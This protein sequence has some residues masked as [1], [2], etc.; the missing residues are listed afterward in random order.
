MAV[1]VAVAVAQ[2]VDPAAEGLPPHPVPGPGPGHLLVSSRRHLTGGGK[3]LLQT[4]ELILNLNLKSIHTRST[5]E[6]ITSIIGIAIAIIGIAITTASTN[7]VL[8]IEI[9]D[10]SSPFEVVHAR[11]G[12]TL[13]T[14]LGHPSTCRS[15]GRGMTDIPLHDSCSIDK[16]C[17][18]GEEK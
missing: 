14:T 18:V 3:S 4:Q 13:A 11:A 7:S 9:E 8:E 10:V 5:T 12:P 6:K 17:F 2:V 1:A 16:G 15:T